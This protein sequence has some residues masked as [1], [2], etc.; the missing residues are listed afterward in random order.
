M[1]AEERLKCENKHSRLYDYFLE[2]IAQAKPSGPHIFTNINK[3]PASPR[4][5]LGSIW[6]HPTV[7]LRILTP[8]A[9]L[10]SRVF[11]ALGLPVAGKDLE[12]FGFTRMEVNG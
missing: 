6:T 4:T 9:V 8:S 10:D 7:T 5:C 1:G 11:S 3:M 12:S 2:D